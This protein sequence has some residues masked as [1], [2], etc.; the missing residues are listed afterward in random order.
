VD[1]VSTLITV[2]GWRRFGQNQEEGVE[3]VLNGQ[4]TYLVLGILQD[5][6]VDYN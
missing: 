5:K 6:T 3:D 1:K 4:S 2:C